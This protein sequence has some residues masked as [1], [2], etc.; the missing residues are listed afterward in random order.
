MAWHPGELLTVSR[1]LD[2]YDVSFLMTPWGGSLTF[3]QALERVRISEPSYR[4][5]TAEPGRYLPADP[6]TSWTENI[7][8]LDSS[9]VPA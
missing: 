6:R 8:P 1:E 4:R 3:E 9:Q 2:L 7:L 5:W